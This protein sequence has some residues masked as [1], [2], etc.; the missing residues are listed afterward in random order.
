MKIDFK[1]FRRQAES[2]PVGFMQAVMPGGRYDKTQG[3]YF[4]AAPNGGSG[5]SCKTSLRPG[6]MFVGQDFAGTGRKWSGP[7]DI[8]MAASGLSKPYEA[9]KWALER[10]R[11]GSL[12]SEEKTPAHKPTLKSLSPPEGSRPNFRL[13]DGREPSLVSEYLRPSNWTLAF[14]IVRYEARDASEKKLIL[15]W[16][17]GERDG[18][19]GW[20]RTIP[21]GER[22]LL[23]IRDIFRHFDAGGKNDRPVLIV[24]GE[25]TFEAAR[26]LVGDQYFVVTWHGGSNGVDKTNWRTLDGFEIVIWPDADEPGHAAALKI[27]GI[28]KLISSNVVKIVEPP[29]GVPLGWDLADAEIEVSRDAES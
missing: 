28:L 1:D 16:A 10:W 15:P 3:E 27:A 5:Q 24:E 11:P 29:A 21:P 8:A 2:D 4:T 13:S 6:K 20:H 18:V 14:I 26:R 23:G 7:I 19:T 22:P 12:P 17:Y 25:K 9:A